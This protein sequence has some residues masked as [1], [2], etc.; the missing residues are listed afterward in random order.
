MEGYPAIG[1]G[2]AI[3]GWLAAMTKK[4]GCKRTML[5][6]LASSPRA[7]RLYV[8]HGCVAETVSKN[9]YKLKI[10]LDEALMTKTIQRMLCHYASYYH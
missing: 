7:I 10:C 3:L 2:N 8:K 1:I 6:V 4:G 5:L 9:R